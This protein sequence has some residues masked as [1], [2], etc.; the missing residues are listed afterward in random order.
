MTC[1][2]YHL[3]DALDKLGLAINETELLLVNDRSQILLAFLKE[4]QRYREMACDHW[5]LSA[6]EKT[7]VDI[8]RVAARELDNMYPDYVTLLSRVGALLREEQQL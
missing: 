2:Q 8:G 5:P 1:S 3:L 4:L 7:T 6:D